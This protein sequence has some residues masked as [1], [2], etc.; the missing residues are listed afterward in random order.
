MIQ[1]NSIHYN[2]VVVIE[3][4]SIRISHIY[5][6]CFPSV[7]ACTCTCTCI[8]KKMQDVQDVQEYGEEENI[9]SFKSTL[10]NQQ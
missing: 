5:N 3:I 7:Y 10:A 2:Y 4:F 9:K 1:Y 6:N 8:L